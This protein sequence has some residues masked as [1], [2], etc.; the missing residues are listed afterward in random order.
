MVNQPI[1]D[2]MPLSGSAIAI[3]LEEGTVELHRRVLLDDLVDDPRYRLVFIEQM[4]LDVENKDVWDC[5]V[6]RVE[7]L[8]IYEIKT[9]SGY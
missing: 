3:I 4:N 5:I 2:K 9:F 8:T 7:T 1:A 6:K